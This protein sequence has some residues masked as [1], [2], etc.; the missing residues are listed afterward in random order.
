MILWQAAS[1][2]SAPNQPWGHHLGCSRGSCLL[3]FDPWLWT[4]YL[5]YKG[6]SYPAADL[7]KSPLKYACKLH[8]YQLY[9]AVYHICRSP[10]KQKLSLKLWQALRQNTQG[11]QTHE[12]LYFTPSLANL[13]LESGGIHCAPGKKNVSI[14][15]SYQKV[16]R[17]IQLL[18]K[19]TTLTKEQGR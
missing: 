2:P 1:P 19:T 13:R 8:V 9:S 6:N 17:A 10:H 14:N 15:K 7:W 12:F 11:S 18:R 3:V 16:L 4:C 5:C